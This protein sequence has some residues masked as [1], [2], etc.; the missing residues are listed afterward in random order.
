MK[1]DECCTRGKMIFCLPQFEILFFFR[2]TH[3]LS[4]SLL[5]D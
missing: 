2:Y 1:Q 5:A 4:F 3:T